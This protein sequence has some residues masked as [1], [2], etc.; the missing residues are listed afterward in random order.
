MTKIAR[1]FF[2][3]GLAG[4]AFF[5]MPLRISAQE[6]PIDRTVLPIRQPVYPPVTE[7]DARNVKPPPVFQVKAPD[8]APNVLIVLLDDMGFGQSSAFGGP[9]HMPTIEALANGGLRSTNFT[10]L[11]FARQPEGRCSPAAITT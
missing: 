7:L 8:D 11:R 10:R 4:L 2:T 3:L 5:G 9:V 1:A 6:V